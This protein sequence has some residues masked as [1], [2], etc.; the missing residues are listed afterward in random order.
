MELQNKKYELEKEIDTMKN[1][2]KQ[3]QM[4][5]ELLF[6]KYQGK[7]QMCLDEADKHARLLHLLEVQ[8]HHEEMGIAHEIHT[9]KCAQ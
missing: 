6:T 5:K 3:E 1:K 8:M 4:K 7:T 2:T 9:L